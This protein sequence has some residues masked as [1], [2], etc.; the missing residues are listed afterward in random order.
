MLETK[1]FEVRDAATFI[2]VLCVR[3]NASYRPTPG[4]GPPARENYLIR[5]AGYR[6]EGFVIMTT[7]SANWDHATYQP[8][9]WAD[10]TRYNAHV[11]IEQ[12]WQDLKTGDV[13]DVRFILG[14]T[15]VPCQPEMFEAAQARAD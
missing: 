1:V 5:R 13:I 15:P 4:D 9:Q 6:E 8:S 2:P 12:Q 14:E 10:R 3:V 11:Y 7:L